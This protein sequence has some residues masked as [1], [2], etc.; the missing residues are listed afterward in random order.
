MSENVEVGKIKFYDFYK[1][2]LTAGSYMLEVE[3]SIDMSNIVDL[4]SSDPV[5]KT[6]KT[7]RTFHVG[8]PRFR[9]GP[10]EVHA[11]YPPANSQGSYGQTLPHI[12]L[13]ERTLP[14]ARSI[15]SNLV[16]R[17]DDP[18]PWVA[19]LLFH[20]DEAP[21][22]ITRSIDDIINPQG[23]AG[24]AKFDKDHPE[25]VKELDKEPGDDK[26][27]A[28]AIDIDATLFKAI[29]PT[30]D[31]LPL[32]THVRNVNTGD[33]ELLGLKEDGWFSVVIS[34][35]LPKA[36][37]QNTVHLVSLEGWYK[38][39]YEKDPEQKRT[40]SGSVRLVSLAS[41]SF[42]SSAKHG[43]FAELM[44]ALNTALL[45]VKP[46]NELPND[47]EVAG[48]GEIV[49]EALNGGYVPLNYETRHGEATAGWYRGPLLPVQTAPVNR[50]PYESAEAA[51]IYDA[52]TGLFDASYAVAWQIG[53]LLALSD[54][55]FTAALQ[56]W[57]REGQRMV[58][59]LLENLDLADRYN[60]GYF[61]ARTQL[62]NVEQQQHDQYLRQLID[63][64]QKPQARSDQLM[65]KVFG[66]EV[67]EK[68]L[69]GGKAPLASAPID[70]ASL[71]QGLPP[72]SD[73]DITRIEE[74]PDV[75]RRAALLRDAL[76]QPI[77]PEE[78]I[79]KGVGIVPDEP[80]SL[81]FMQQEKSI[82]DDLQQ[83]LQP[84]APDAIASFLGR[85]ALLYGIPFENLV[86]DVRMLPQESIRFF[87]IDSNW[88]EALVDGAL[89]IGVH[90]ERDIRYSKVMQYGIRDATAK[91]SGTLRASL[92]NEA[93]QVNNT[94]AGE[95]DKT[96]SSTR[97][98]FLMRSAIVSGW[99]GLEVCGY[100]TP[101]EDDA[102]RLK[103][104]RLE[105][106]SPDVLLCIFENIPK[107]VVIN[108][109]A[110]DFH[111]GVN[112]N[113][114]KLQLRDPQNGERL[115][116]PGDASIDLPMRNDKGV[117]NIKKLYDDV[118]RKLKTS[119]HSLGTAKSNFAVQMIDAAD[120][121]TFTNESAVSSV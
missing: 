63:D 65:E 56:T 36:E 2:R 30:W 43:N 46:P 15:D 60:V 93:P 21:K 12:V 10:N 94:K 80:V 98:G 119:N 71:R 89:S 101:A 88:L 27:Q 1:P 90:S 115:N 117:I 121:Q 97:A 31:E 40:I 102:A 35:R 69:L 82:I 28:R 77:P 53:R 84:H 116:P 29:A 16:E 75:G 91:A 51:L 61:L 20:G 47:N 7:E 26:G 41:W 38:F 112:S 92:R 74:E 9:L 67:Q 108:E 6:Y 34:N 8:G 55:K 103:L 4:S 120:K 72:L 39:L 114:L 58:D 54:G 78:L 57:R 11:V 70:K 25:L 18:H 79:S 107:L 17:D 52:R 113:T 14:W 64:V 110:E 45:H 68:L 22:I 37:A 3:Q 19:L 95:N 23:V 100:Q 118:S 109:P 86:P 13:R 59:R 42:W 44:T 96:D 85:L 48:A 73:E 32:L 5:G 106:L 76:L 104:L 62:D 83:Q 24:P 50:D 99:P 111:F 66:A 87:Y 81:E 33:K 105:R 49:R